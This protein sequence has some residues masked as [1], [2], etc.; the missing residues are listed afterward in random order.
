MLLGACPEVANSAEGQRVSGKL[1][2]ERI[3]AA[4]HNN[5]TYCC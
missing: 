1:S 3:R 2:A 4:R 5:K